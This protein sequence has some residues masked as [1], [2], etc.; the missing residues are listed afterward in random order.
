MLSWGGTFGSVVSAINRVE[1]EGREV[2]HL[3]LRYLNP[4]PKNLGEV[5]S[6]YEKVLVPE[7]NFGQ[8]AHLI[9]AKYLIPTVPF[10]KVRGQPFAISEV[11]S[12]IE[13]L[14]P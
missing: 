12:K 6:R 2:A 5:L 7:L 13:E 4:F 3:H 10:S 8:L 11:Q 9:R 14:L 1:E